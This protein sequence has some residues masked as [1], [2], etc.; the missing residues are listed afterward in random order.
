MSVRATRPLRPEAKFMGRQS[1]LTFGADLLG[2]SI[3]VRGGPGLCE[4]I[5]T[6]LVTQ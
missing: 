4:V 6:Q 3:N 5:V 1:G 2:V